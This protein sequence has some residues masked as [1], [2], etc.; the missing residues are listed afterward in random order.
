MLNVLINRG[1]NLA[2]PELVKEVIAR[3]SWSQNRR[4]NVI[5]SYTKFLEFQD[6]TWNPPRCKIVC[7]IPFI[8]TEQEIDDLIA[9]C[10]N[11]V[12]TF[13]LL[14]KETAMRCGEAL[15]LKWKNVDLQRRIITLNDP[16]KDSNPRIFNELSGKLLTMLNTLPKEN[17]YLF[18]T[19][20]RNSLKNTLCRARKR[21]AYKLGNSRLNKIH[22]HTLRHWKA[23][24]L[25][26]Y[27]PD[28]LLVAEFLS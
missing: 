14:L 17:E 13:L 18:G 21:L 11:T 23:T 15:R 6:L 22:F 16:E 5:T 2:E 26:H 7:K 28:I 9:G 24:M 8:P 3:Q 19:R 27:K 25:Y 4:R 12:A 20:T 1:A 10:P